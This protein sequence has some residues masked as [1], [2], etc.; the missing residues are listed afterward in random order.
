MK[1]VRDGDI[2]IFERAIFPEHKHDIEKRGAI[3]VARYDK[4]S[5]KL[6]VI[7]EGDTFAEYCGRVEDF[8]N[9]KIGGNVYDNPN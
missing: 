7:L 4:Y 1:K 6:S 5:K 9:F 2:L 8:Q 3:Y